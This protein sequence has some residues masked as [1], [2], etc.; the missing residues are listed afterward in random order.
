[1][2]LLARFRR[3]VMA[4][5]SAQL[6][7]TVGNLLLVPLFLS[8]WSAAVYG[9]WLAL[10]S[11][12]GYL[13]A[14]S[15]PNMAANVRLTQ[16][17][18]RNE[19]EEYA[20]CQHSAMAAFLCLAG[21][22]TLLLAA[23]SWFL[24]IPSWLGLKH[25]SRLDAFWVTVLMG[26]Q[27]LW[28][29]PMGQLSMI[30]QTTGDL[31]K[32]IWIMNLQ[33]LVSV[34]F[35]ATTLMLGGGLK[36]AALVQLA[37]VFGAGALIWMHLSR[38]R[39]VLLPGV[40][41][42]SLRI[43]R[44][45]VQ[46]SLF[47][48][49]CLVALAVSQQ[50]PVML[51]SS[52]LGGVAVA[53]FVTSRTLAHAAKQLAAALYNSLWPDLT[54]MKARQEYDRLRFFY[55]V[56]VIGTGAVCAALAGALWY[57]GGE[58]IATWTRGKLEPDV[59]LLRLLLVQL[60]LQ[61]PWMASLALTTAINQHANASRLYLASSLLGL[62]AA[63]LLVGP[64]GLRG[65]PIGLMIGEALACYHF[66]VKDACKLIKLPYGPFARQLWRGTAAV[67][68]ITLAAGWLAHYL[69]WGPKLLRWAEVGG[70]TCVAALL[71]S[72]WLSFDARLR[73]AF[74]ERLWPADG[75]RRLAAA[76]LGR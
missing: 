36:S 9:E 37:P 25:V 41:K 72:W 49:M 48:L 57:E 45:L 1:M 39:P 73:A 44:E 68:L 47:F 50:G 15:F 12:V 29:V 75:R 4:I 52:L 16:C 58:V 8:R 6:L 34:L 71:S 63:A 38:T 31:A 18:A 51:I 17:Y 23:A 42:A 55:R 32:T 67:G 76:L 3:G 35:V 33:R 19:L 53:I 14:L 20:R 2:S 26:S 56:Q 40:S 66:V 24:P 10:F 54:R 60:V 27:V 21:A 11:L 22:G 28:A 13:S 62:G 59:V 70:M 7:S 64:M 74:A 69:A 61:G 30:F 65:L 46:P 43:M 5:V